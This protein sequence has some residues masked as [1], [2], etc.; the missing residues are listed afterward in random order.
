M[1]KPVITIEKFL[2]MQICVPKEW[3]K[4]Q[5]ESWV[6][7]ERECGT[8][9]GWMLTEDGDS[10]LNGARAEVTCADDPSMKHVVV[11]A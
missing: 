6:N 5:I 3:D 10:I 11:A 7:S 9:N 1:S 2:S 8:T 4:E